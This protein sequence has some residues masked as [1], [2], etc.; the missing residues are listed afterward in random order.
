M[1]AEQ[2]IEKYGLSE[3]LSWFGW[4]GGTRWQAIEAI[5]EKLGKHGIVEVNGVFCSLIIGGSE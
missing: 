3:V 4:S 2:I 5:K 1:N